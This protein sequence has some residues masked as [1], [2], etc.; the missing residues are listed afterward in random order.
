MEN[1]IKINDE[2]A[3]T[4]NQITADQLQEA[5]LEGYQSVMN[6]RSP[7]EEDFVTEEALQV[8]A[9]GLQYFHIPIKPGT[10]TEEL[11]EAVFK[12]IDEVPKPVIIHCKSGIRSGAMALMSMAKNQHLTAEQVLNKATEMGLNYDKNP[13]IK[14]F[15]TQYLGKK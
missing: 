14:E 4:T 5:A 3:I 13:K 15:M 8:K 10:L 12:H 9:A 7:E 11:A 6:L 1:L 2:L